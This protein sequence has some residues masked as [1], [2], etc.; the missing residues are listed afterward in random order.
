M[1]KR[2]A[3]SCPLQCFGHGVELRPHVKTQPLLSVR[4]PQEEAGPDGLLA[5]TGR[6]MF[7]K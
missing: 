5:P 3:V 7:C 6:P 2:L 4:V 1:R